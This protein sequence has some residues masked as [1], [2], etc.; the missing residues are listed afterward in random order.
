[1]SLRTSATRYAKALLVV[2]I[3]ESDPARIEADLSE[4]V[5]AMTTSSELRRA[6]LNPAVPQSARVSLVRALSDRA[7]V[8]APLAK[9]LVM[10]AERGRLELLPD[11]LDVYRERLLAHSNIVRGRVTSAVPLAPERVHALEE[12]LG[13]RTG[14][15]V[16]LDPAVDPALIGGVVARIGSTV[17][18]GSI[19]MQLQKMRQQ[20]VGDQ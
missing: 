15:H 8:Q 2:A 14:K 12:S 20:M 10:L 5:G 11:L 1:M 4:I 6:M 18:D 19:R 17:Y 7:G 9:L 13:A 16:Q 3:Q